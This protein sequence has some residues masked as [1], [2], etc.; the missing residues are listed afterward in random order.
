MTLYINVWFNKK[1][2]DNDHNINCKFFKVH[3][4]KKLKMQSKK[5]NSEK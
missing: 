5:S 3:F 2:I 4:T 1:S